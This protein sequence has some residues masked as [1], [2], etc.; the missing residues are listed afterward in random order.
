MN[1]PPAPTAVDEPEVK[2]T[3]RSNSF[4]NKSQAS[5]ESQTAAELVSQLFLIRHELICG[6]FIRS[7]ELLEADAREALPYVRHLRSPSTSLLIAD[8]SLEH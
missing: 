3:A 8:I 5:D 1:P 6:R 4:S 7:Q 2:V